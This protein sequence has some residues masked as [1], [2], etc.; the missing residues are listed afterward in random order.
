MLSE[1]AAAGRAAGAA[2][3]EDGS[4]RVPSGGRGPGTRP[5]ARLGAWLRIAR[6]VVHLLVGVLTLLLPYRLAAPPRR[7]ALVRNWSRRLL[8]ICGM[9]LRVRYHVAAAPSSGQRETHAP[10]HAGLHA[11]LHAEAPAG[12]QAAIPTDSAASAAEAPALLVANHISWI[13]IFVI[14]GWRP[15]HFV[16]KSEI[17]GWPVIGWLASEVGTL[18]IERGKRSDAKRV[19]DV[20]AQHIGAGE[21]VALFAEGTTSDGSTVLP[22]HANLFAAAHA[23]GAPVRPIAVRYEDADGFRTDAPAFVGETTLYASVM[24]LLRARPLTAWLTIGPPLASEGLT[25]RALADTTRQAIIAML[26]ED[27]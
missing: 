19:V 1:P 3:S 18:F 24:A 4:A 6:L 15:T 7:A 13:D 27:G 2:Q 20:L 22:F 26:P 23:A 16:A 21:P 8:A 11:G 25:R 17:R 9:T 12:L 14:D 5:G 10:L